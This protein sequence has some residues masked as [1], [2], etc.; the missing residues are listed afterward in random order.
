MT[1]HTY[2]AEMVAPN[3]QIGMFAR[4]QNIGYSGA[5]VLNNTSTSGL[6]PRQSDAF[7]S[8]IGFAPLGGMERNYKTRKGNTVRRLVAVI[9]ILPTPLNNG[10]PV[11]TRS[12]AMSK[13]THTPAAQPSSNA[14]TLREIEI[15]GATEALNHAEYSMFVIEELLAIFRA[16]N[17]LS[18]GLDDTIHGLAVVGNRLAS[19]HHNSFDNERKKAEIKLASMHATQGVL[20]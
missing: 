9:N 20:K 18:S 2:H 6:H 8:S 7:F 15:D 11:S 12:K 5:Q 19:D 4:I 1:G 14:L 16:I 13:S 10:F 17:T 3:I